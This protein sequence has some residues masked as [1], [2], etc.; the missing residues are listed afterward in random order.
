ME[1]TI[2]QIEDEVMA[3]ALDIAANHLAVSTTH[4]FMALNECKGICDLPC[5]DEE[6]KKQ[7]ES[8][9]NAPAGMLKELI[10]MNG[11]LLPLLQDEQPGQ[12]LLQSVM[13]IPL[14]NFTA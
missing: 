6:L 12:G 7:R 9:M 14:Q 8:I 13:V 11:G 3:K 2:E 10:R 1:K 4:Y 5:H